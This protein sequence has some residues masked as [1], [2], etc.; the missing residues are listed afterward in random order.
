MRGQANLFVGQ[1]I[2]SVDLLYLLIVCDLTSRSGSP[3][4]FPVIKIMSIFMK[5]IPLHS[6]Y[7]LPAF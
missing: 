4:L 2:F 5:G 7:T 6:G 1:S 3:N